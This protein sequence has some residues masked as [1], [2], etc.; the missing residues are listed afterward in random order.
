[1]EDWANM[2]K[3]QNRRTPVLEEGMA[4]KQ[5][6]VSPEDA[7]ILESR[8]FTQAQ[9]SAAYG[10]E[11][12][13]PQDEEERRQFYADVLQPLCERLC[14]FLDLQVLRTEY[15]LDDY[16]FEFNLDEKKMSDDRLKAITSAAGA[17][18]LLRNEGR[19]MLNLPAVPEGDEL[20]TP[21]NVIVGGK[22][23]PQI[24]PVQNPLKPSQDGDFREEP[25]AL[26][27]AA[28][29]E[30]PQYVPRRRAAIERQHRNVDKGIGLMVRHFNRMA[31]SYS[32]K[33]SPGFDRRRWDKELSGDIHDLITAVFEHEGGIT[34][35]LLGGD[36]FDLRRVEHYLKGMSEGMAEAINQVTRRDIAEMGVDEALKHARAE[37]SQTAGAAIGARSTVEARMKAAEQAPNPER[38]VKTWVAHTE[39]HADADGVTVPIGSGWP[40]GFAPG[41]APN[42][43]CSMIVE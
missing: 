26:A 41:S 36:D 13:P 35:A 3:V 15:S 22:P 28:D 27:K 1:M 11:H 33:A 31:R 6:G 14:A 40:I 8:Q 39:R 34:M 19:A 42:C 21:L 2:M 16:Y 17:P 10:M 43:R 4:F 9:A 7:Q 5:A 18:V 25:K 20:V 32:E 29:G 24:M 12:C 23:S 37:R 30:V 38:R